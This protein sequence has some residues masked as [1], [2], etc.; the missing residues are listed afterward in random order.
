MQTDNSIANAGVLSTQA[1]HDA[2][3]QKIR[4]GRYHVSFGPLDFLF[5]VSLEMEAGP[6]EEK[7]E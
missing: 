2:I 6:G 5:C 1:T 3:I 4:S 7:S